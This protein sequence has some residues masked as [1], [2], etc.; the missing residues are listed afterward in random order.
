MAEG[1]WQSASHVLA[2]YKLADEARWETSKRPHR[3]EQ[4]HSAQWDLMR[5]YMI[6]GSRWLPVADSSICPSLSVSV[7]L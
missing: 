3:G 5:D 4:A 7:S 1:G 6:H 2:W